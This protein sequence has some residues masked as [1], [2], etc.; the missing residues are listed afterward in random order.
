MTWRNAEKAIWSYLWIFLVLMLLHVEAKELLPYNPIPS[1]IENVTKTTDRSMETVLWY[2]DRYY[3]KASLHSKLE[4]PNDEMQRIHRFVT[5]YNQISA[6]RFRRQ[7]LKLSSQKDIPELSDYIMQSVWYKRYLIPVA[8]QPLYG[9]SP[10]QAIRITIAGHTAA[11]FFQ[12]PFPA[13]MCLIFQESKFDFD[14]RSYTGAL[15]LGQLTTI[16]L[17]QVEKLREDP[18]DEKRI[19]AAAQHLRNI[20]QDPVLNEIIK[21]MGIQYKFDDL[22]E[23]PKEIQSIQNDVSMFIKEVG[24]EVVRQG[25]PY[26]E[27][28]KLMK[29]LV[30]RILRGDVLSGKYAAIHP[31]VDTVTERRYGKMYG[32]VLNIETNILLTAM[33]LRYYINYP[34]RINN[35]RLHFEP[36]VRTII[37]ISAYN[38]GQQTIRKWLRQ[39]KVQHPDFDFEKATLRDFAP[40]FSK[41]SLQKVLP[42]SP[43]RVHEAFKHVWNI[44]ECSE[45]PPEDPRE[46]EALMK[47][48][49]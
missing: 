12:L 7:V 21:Q 10:D 36:S 27:N 11:H 41:E 40:F 45:R 48:Y 18:K 35:K 37:A 23:F 26:G 5:S 1:K 39:L 43:T 29:A 4:F 33:L 6:L 25:K 14:I 46:L 15:G 2:S 44:T 20:Y 32:S 19:Q 28:E 34:W 22:G 9:Y 30:Q 3:K 42:D 38:Q 24:E 31:A 13:M 47:L 8:T 17:A 49:E 16:G